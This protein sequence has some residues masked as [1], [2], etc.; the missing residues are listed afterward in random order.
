M[1]E[2]Y[3]SST[4]SW[5]SLPNMPTKRAG[6]A[7]VVFHE[8]KMIVIGGVDENQK[9]VAAVDCFDLD[10]ET[11][12]QLPELPTGVTG[13]YITMV[14]GQIYC[15]GGTDKKEINQSVVFDFDRN[16]WSSLPPMPTKRYACGGYVYEN[17]IYIVGGRD[18]RDPIQACE[19]FDLETKQWEKLAPMPSIRVFYNIAAMKDNIYALGG[20]VPMVGFTKIAEKYNITENKWERMKDLSIERSDGSI[21]VVGGKLVLVAGIGGNPPEPLAGGECVRH[22]G[23][24]WKKVP[25]MV[26]GRSSTTTCMCNGKMAVIGG[27]GHGGPQAAVD[28]LRYGLH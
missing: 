25:G 23:K 6:G 2:V 20:L 8:K 9:T 22:G 26:K 16:E 18:G 13:P 15:I 11:W 21:G 3:D 4:K 28:I 12:E 10:K 14:N 27:A 1:I 24:H 19:S 7:G 17:K 5:H